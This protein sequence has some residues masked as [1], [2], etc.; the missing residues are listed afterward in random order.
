MG[1]YMRGEKLA[2]RKFD[3]G[4]GCSNVLETDDKEGSSALEAGSSALEAVD[5]DGF[6]KPNTECELEQFKVVAAR[7]KRQFPLWH[8]S[9]TYL[10]LSPSPCIFLQTSH[11]PLSRFTTGNSQFGSLQHGETLSTAVYQ[12]LNSHV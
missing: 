8:A 3:S 1:E 2:R 4:F 7:A 6:V 5:K 12:F 11:P 10:A 9:I